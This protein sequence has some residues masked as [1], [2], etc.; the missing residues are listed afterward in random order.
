MVMNKLLSIL[1]E[2]IDKE[3]LREYFTFPIGNDNFNVGYDSGGLGRGKK[4]I[5]DKDLAF[6]NSDYGEGDSKHQK[7]GGH[8]GIDIFAPKGTPLVACVSGKIVKIGKTKVGGNRVTIQDDRGLNYY[9]AHM[10]KILPSL[11]RGDLV[12]AGEFIGTVGDSGNAKGTH[13]HLHFSIYDK[14]GYKRGNI[15]PWP[16]LSS[17]LDNVN[18]IET[19]PADIEGLSLDFS[20]LPKDIKISDII[21]NQDNRDLITRGARGESVEEFQKILRDLGYDLGEF[22]PN[23][24]GVDGKF[25]RMTKEAIKSFQRDH[26]LEVDGIIGINTATALSTYK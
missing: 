1:S 9:Y 26:G 19:L 14:R 6:H 7:R 5:L 2:Q 18:T 22:G 24:D 8:G 11:K 4:K 25:G 23:G 20:T 17:Q 21:D 16:F 3:I 10:D 12:S 13:P 15:N